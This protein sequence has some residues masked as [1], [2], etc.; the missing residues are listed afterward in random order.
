V[1][2]LVAVRQAGTLGRELDDKA[3]DV[4]PQAQ[5]QPLARQIDRRDL[6]PM[7]RVNNDE[8]IGR[9][10]VD[11]LMHWRSPKAGHLLQILHCKET[12][13]LEFAF[14]NKIFDPLVG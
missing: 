6:K 8:R 12:A 10:L 4:A 1:K 11:C 9:E 7:S 13:G 5:Q 14:D 2:G 3:L